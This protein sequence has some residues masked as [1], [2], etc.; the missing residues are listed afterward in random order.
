VIVAVIAALAAGCTFAIGS[1]LQ[2]DA[3]RQAPK[4]MSLSW[5]LLVDLAHRP[6]WLAGIAMD[7]GSFGLQ[8]L[9][10]AFGPIA[11]V[12]PLLVTG[13]LFSVPLSARVH[14]KRLGATEWAGTAAVA[15]GLS[16]F[17]LCAG[18]SEGVSQTGIGTWAL[19]LI[20]V[21]G[22]MA[23]GV[24]AGGMTTGAFRA[25]LWAMSAGAAFGVLA[26]LTKSSTWLLGQGAVTFFTSWEPYA[27]AFAAF[28]G[29]ICQQSAFQAAPLPASMPV[30]DS[31]EPTVAVLIGVFAFEESLA[32]S[33]LALAGEAAGIIALITGIVVLDRS[34][35]VLEMLDEHERPATSGQ[36]HPIPT[37]PFGRNSGAGVA[38]G[39]Q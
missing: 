37:A 19:I 9:A 10:L 29:I 22:F 12:Q 26:A 33:A 38:D 20:A 21:G 7:V 14:G 15:G 5:R 24:I 28:A 31:V 17:L 8:A 1:V 32:T 2:Q 3:A 11:L 27:M 4:E 30:M 36:T 25:S 23:F 16:L 34:R 13:I 39:A 6:K 35:V 18:P